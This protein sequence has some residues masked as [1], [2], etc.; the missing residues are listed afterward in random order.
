MNEFSLIKQY[1]QSLPIKHK[2]VQFGIGDDAACLRLPAGMDLLVSTDTLVSGVHFLPD[3]DAYSIAYRALMVNI[4]DIAAMGAQAFSITLALTLSQIDETWLSA[5]AQGL[6]DALD[7]YSID[8][9]GGDTTHGPLAL[10]IT[11]MGMAPEGTSIRRSGAK[12]GDI[13]F[14][15]GELGA[16]ALALKFLDKADLPSAE[17]AELMQKLLR[18]KPRVDLIDHMRKYASSAID[19]SDGLSADLNHI[20]SAS[21]LGACITKDAL[22]VH[23]LVQKYLG[24][25]AV[26]LA[27]SGGDDYELCF[28]V[29]VLKLDAFMQELQRDGLLCYAV[30]QIEKQPGMRIKLADGSC[31]ELVAKGYQHFT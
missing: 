12:E 1:F 7:Q 6:G 28:T 24:E 31:E 9:I 29:P 27:L 10:T 5:F 3:W 25:Q 17:K 23:P 13:I 19:I 30:G 11:I 22:P 14:V 15:S 2:E 20:C 21:E 8:L 18:P 16:A 4:S 26:D